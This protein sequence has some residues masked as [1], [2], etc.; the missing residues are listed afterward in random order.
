MTTATQALSALDS[1]L[2]AIAAAA[3]RALTDGQVVLD[4]DGDPIGVTYYDAGTRRWYAA[5]LDDCRALLTRIGARERDAYSRW[6]SDTGSTEH[7]YRE[8]AAVEL[9]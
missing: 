4:T 8:D 3:A 5:D 2:D 7:E 9:F 6:C 1:D